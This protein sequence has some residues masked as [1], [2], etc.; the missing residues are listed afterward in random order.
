MKRF[1]KLGI[2]LLIS[3][4]VTDYSIRNLF[5]AQSPKLN[6]FFVSNLMAKVNNFFEKK[7]S[8]LAFKKPNLTQPSNLKQQP[9]QSIVAQKP[10]F[11]PFQIVNTNDLPQNVIEAINTPLQKIST[12]VYAGEK[13]DIKVIEIRTGE[14]EYLEYT[15][16][17]KGKEIKIKVPKDQEPPSQE[18]I[19]AL[20][21]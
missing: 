18:V 12:G 8:F 15:F 21:K 14:I 10:S 9:T 5:L 17:I 11:D 19:E 4:L 6:P 7:T 20:Y 3:Y 2:V 1:I 16:N 13:N